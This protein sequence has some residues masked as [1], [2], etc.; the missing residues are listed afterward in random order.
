MN[1]PEDQI[2]ALL[3][4]QNTYVDDNGFTARVIQSLPQRRRAWLRPVIILGAAAIGSV[5]AIRWL[6][7]RNLPPLDLSALTSPN[8][9]MLVPWILVISVVSS[10]VWST[11]VALQRED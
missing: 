5:L 4:E 9:Q 11:V 2:D 10:L 3:R 7:W 8:S 6:P 1:T